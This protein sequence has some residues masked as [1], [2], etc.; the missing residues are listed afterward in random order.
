MNRFIHVAALALLATLT[1]LTG[2]SQKAAEP[3]KSSN[4][5]ATAATED[6]HP[7]AAGE[8]GEELSLIHI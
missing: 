4:P 2:C 7:E 3:P 1:T 5:P 6:K 8:H